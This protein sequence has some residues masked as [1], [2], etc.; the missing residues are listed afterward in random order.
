[1]PGCG[2]RG[3]A[4]QR[5]QPPGPP[6]QRGPGALG[7]ARGCTW[8]LSPQRP[9]ARA[10]PG[11][12]PAPRSP[13]PAPR[14]PPGEEASTGSSTGGRQLRPPPNAPHLATGADRTQWRR[15]R[16]EEAEWLPRWSHPRPPLPAPTSQPLQPPPSPDS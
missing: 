3:T 4:R 15:R 5:T 13:G 1:M 6:G 12:G 8:D 16:E 9:G 7:A 11:Q 10:R 14:T 2:P